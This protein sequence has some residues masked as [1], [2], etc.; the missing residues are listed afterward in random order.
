MNSIYAIKQFNCNCWWSV[1]T[2]LWST[3][4][5]N[6]RLEPEQHASAGRLGADLHYSRH[7]RNEVTMALRGHVFLCLLLAY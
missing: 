7:L 2:L 4:L 5:P 1:K 6:K 3:A